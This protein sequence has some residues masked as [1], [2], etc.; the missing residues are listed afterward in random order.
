LKE[1]LKK[2]TNSLGFDWGY[3][4]VDYILQEGTPILI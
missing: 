1:V 2:A 3:F 4:M